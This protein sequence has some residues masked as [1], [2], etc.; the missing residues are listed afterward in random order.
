ML[1][2]LRSEVGILLLEFLYL[3]SL[4]LTLEFA[5]IIFESKSIWKAE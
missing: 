1:C 4:K 5:H 2:G 3:K